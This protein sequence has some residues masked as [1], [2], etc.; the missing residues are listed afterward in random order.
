[1][2]NESWLDWRQAGDANSANFPK[3]LKVSEAGNSNKKRK[4]C[5]NNLLFP[6]IMTNHQILVIMSS[7][8]TIQHHWCHLGDFGWYPTSK[9]GGVYHDD[10]NFRFSN[11]AP[12]DTVDKIHYSLFVTTTDF[13]FGNNVFL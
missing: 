3:L 1:M 8:W 5:W 4:R 13:G 7:F 11:N 6:Q 2:H 9:L 10:N 12:R